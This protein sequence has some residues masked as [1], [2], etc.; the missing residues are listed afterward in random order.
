MINFKHIIIG[1]CLSLLLFSCKRDWNDHF[2][3]N[4][5][6][7]NTSLWV[8]VQKD[9]N[10]TQFVKYINKYHFDTLFKSS[11]KIYTLFIPSDKAFTSYVDDSVYT[12]LLLK[13]LISQYYIQS[14]NIQGKR[15]IQTLGL[16]YPLFE[17]NGSNSYFDGISLKFESPLYING[18]FYIMDSIAYPK[19][20]LYEY[21]SRDNLTFKNFIDS[22]DSILVDKT[23]STPIGYDAKGNVIYDTVPIIYN[24]FE[25]KY[26]PVSKESRYKT[27]TVVFPLQDDYNNALTLVAQ[28]LNKQGASYTD[29]RDI[30]LTWQNDVLIPYLAKFGVFENMLEPSEFVNPHPKDT[31]KLKNILGDSVVIKYQV[32]QKTI[33]SNGYAYNYQN[34]TVPDTVWNGI[35]RFEAERLIKQNGVNNYSWIPGVN[36]SY[37]QLLMPIKEYNKGIASNDSSLKV[38]IPAAYSG[39]YSFEFN[40][41]RLLPRKYLMVIHT[42]Y[43]YGGIFDIYVNDQLVVSDFNYQTKNT[44]WAFNG[45]RFPSVTGKL[46]KTYTATW[47][48]PWINFDCF[49]TPTVYGTCK[50]KVVYKGKCASNKINPGISIDYI[51]FKPYW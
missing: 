16:K 2:A 30:P 8:D 21:Y 17:R 1:I 44:L 24:S 39:N 4:V 29:Y 22:K 25:A 49:I 7:V 46:I 6:T 15:K 23:K 42:N 32:T 13:Y 18:K 10:L 48:N 19:L 5:K 27:A 41:N 9:S 50:I 33:C 20:N 38:N 45:I 26:F 28:K 34:F 11:D 40:V 35:Y 14:E 51:D 3:I 31:F 47:S 12:R 43:S 37:T 36:V